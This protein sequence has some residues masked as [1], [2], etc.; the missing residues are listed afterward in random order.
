VRVSP[1]QSCFSRC[2]VV[3]S[4]F[5]VFVVSSLG[6]FLVSGPLGSRC[7]RGDDETGESG[8]RASLRAIDKRA[9]KAR[10]KKNLQL[11]DDL[12]VERLSLLQTAQPAKDDATVAWTRGY[13]ALLQADKSKR[14]MQYTEACKPLA[15][16][17]KPFAEPARGEPVFGDIAVKLFEVV[18]AATALHPDFLTR[19]LDGSVSE[20]FLRQ[21][22]QAAVKND[23]CQVEAAA[24]LA[25]L[26]K[27][28][29]E[30]A[31]VPA[32]QR[33]SLRERN[34]ILLDISAPKEMDWKFVPWFAPA[35][36]LKAQSSSFVL[37]DLSYYTS[38]LNERGFRL[39]GEDRFGEQFQ[40]VLGGALLLYS[41]EQGGSSKKLAVA[42]FLPDTKEWQKVRLQVLVIQAAGVGDDVVVDEEAILRRIRDVGTKFTQSQPDETNVRQRIEE[43]VGEFEK[44]VR[45]HAKS[46]IERTESLDTRLQDLER[47]FGRYGAK[48]SEHAAR[49][50]AAEEKIAGMRKQFLEVQAA[51]NQVKQSLNGLPGFA[52]PPEG[53]PAVPQAG[54]GLKLS[55]DPPGGDAGANLEAWFADRVSSVRL[56]GEELQKSGQTPPGFDTLIEVIRMTTLMRRNITICPGLIAKKEQEKLNCDNEISQI[57]EQ[58][59]KIKKDPAFRPSIDI[60]PERKRRCETQ[61]RNS[62]ALQRDLE[63]YQALVSSAL[64]GTFLK[65]PYRKILEADQL[66]TSIVRK[67]RESGDLAVS[68]AYA[69]ESMEDSVAFGRIRV[70]EALARELRARKPLGG[71]SWECQG[72]QWSVYDLPDALAPDIVAAAIDSLPR[73]G[74]PPDIE[75]PKVLERAEKSQRQSG[76]MLNT[77]AEFTAMAGCPIGEM[78][79]SGVAW[80]TFAV[81]PRDLLEPSYVVIL[82][83]EDAVGAPG[84]GPAFMVDDAGVKSLQLQYDGENIPF[85]LDADAGQPTLTAKFPVTAQTPCIEGVLRLQVG[86]GSRFLRDSRQYSITRL[87]EPD[88]DRFYQIVSEGGREL[89]DRSVNYAKKDWRGLDRNIVNEFMPRVMVEHVSLPAWKSYRKELQRLSPDGQWIWALPREAFSR[90]SL[91]A[92]ERT[93]ETWWE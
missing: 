38:F 5:K 68:D 84:F 72:L 1:Q 90:E 20:D 49:A 40:V 69:S 88:I 77:L 73:L 93:Q 15:E 37:D 48:F 62:V 25:F 55:P 30:E 63:R 71:G 45:A 10:D 34:R 36:F 67:S 19:E 16:A 11:V 41:P 8:L 82:T 70:L 27:P 4:F 57:S 35:E 18:Q 89:S 3:R 43:I 29:P 32:D 61:R 66:A 58:I 50:H 17:W 65:I 13:E 51:R 54:Q 22:L 2:T 12:R 26:E 79:V 44:I 80:N 6:F 7:S 91:R 31:F 23:P 86:T 33:P 81:E 64:M 74:L 60:S 76:I 9:R 87:D 21:A 28:K 52:S 83:P 46:I 14:M 92:P 39:T 53:Q 47:G 56:I 59:E 42:R 78:T 85:R 24:M 75:L